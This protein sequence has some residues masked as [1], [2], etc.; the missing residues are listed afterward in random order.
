M[1]KKDFFSILKFIFVLFLLPDCSS[2]FL[3]CLMLSFKPVS[4]FL[5]NDHF[6]SDT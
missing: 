5:Q 1:G 3:S 2:N 4:K 6:Q